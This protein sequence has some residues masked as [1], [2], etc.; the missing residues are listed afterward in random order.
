M[1]S[2]FVSEEKIC[3]DCK[4]EFMSREAGLGDKYCEVCVSAFKKCLDCKHHFVTR[5]GESD[6]N[7]CGNCLEY[8]EKCDKCEGLCDPYDEELQVIGNNKYCGAC[9]CHNC[10]DALIYENE[11]CYK[12]A[13][14]I[15]ND[16]ERERERYGS[17]YCY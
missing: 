14:E 9:I 4:T 7:V 6:A 3:T 10:Y 12:C 16:D 17:C 11:V 1:E 2:T 15:E 5:E 13:I 8:Y